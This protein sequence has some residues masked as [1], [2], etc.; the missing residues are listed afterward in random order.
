M[1]I[2]S[3]ME[4]AHF[5]AMLDRLYIYTILMIRIILRHTRMWVTNILQMRVQVGWGLEYVI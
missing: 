2:Y 4:E 3:V 1:V 5:M